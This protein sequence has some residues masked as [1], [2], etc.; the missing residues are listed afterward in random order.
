MDVP[1][2]F[3]YHSGTVVREYTTEMNINGSSPVIYTIIN[4]TAD[5]IDINKIVFYLTD[6]AE[7]DDAKFGAVTALSKGVTIRIKRSTGNYELIST[8]KNNAELAMISDNFNY[9]DKT[10]AG[11]YGLIATVRFNG[12]EQSG[13]A[14]RLELNEELQLI[15]KDDISGLTSFKC[16]AFGHFAED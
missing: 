9:R 14:I 4:R 16:L 13:V 3:P 5:P 15:I 7:M 1:V 10:S 2:N 8:V 11:E 12:Q 6:D